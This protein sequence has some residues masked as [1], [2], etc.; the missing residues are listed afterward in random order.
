MSNV[1]WVYDVECL[2]C[3]DIHENTEREEHD[4]RPLMNVCPKCG[5]TRQR[6]VIGTEL[7]VE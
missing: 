6:V 3:G 4:F 7:R 1:E 5:G 2:S